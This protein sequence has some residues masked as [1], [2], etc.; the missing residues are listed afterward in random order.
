MPSSRQLP[1]TSHTVLFVASYSPYLMAGAAIAAVLLLLTRRW[2]T[3][4]VAIALTAAAIAAELPLH[5]SHPAADS[6]AVRVLT[7]NLR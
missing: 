7:A 5:R 4:A 3:A 6:T 1:I 2:L